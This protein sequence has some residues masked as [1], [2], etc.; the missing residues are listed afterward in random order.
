M[1]FTV[2]RVSPTL[3]V[4]L[5]SSVTTPGCLFILPRRILI[6]L[7]NL[8]IAIYGPRPF[9]VYMVTSTIWWFLMILPIICG[10]FYYG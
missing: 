9:L 5:V 6:S 7:S 8:F 1:L 2:I 4:M 10:L 3:Y